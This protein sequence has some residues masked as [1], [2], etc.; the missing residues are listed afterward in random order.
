MRNKKNKARSTKFSLSKCDEVVRCYS[1]TQIAYARYLEMNDLC[2]SFS[3]NHDIGKVGSA[4]GEFTTDFLIKITDGG[5]AVRECVSAATLTR[6][7][8]QQQLRASC[9]YWE[10]AGITDWKLVVLRE[11]REAKNGT[12]G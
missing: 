11:I 10:E 7:S 3:C 8:V 2:E 4:E 5:Y 1:D 12:E 6:P 9:R